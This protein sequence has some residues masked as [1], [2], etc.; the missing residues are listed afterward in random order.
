LSVSKLN[1]PVISVGNLTTGGTGKTPYVEWLCCAISEQRSPSGSGKRTRTCVLTRG[2]GRDTPKS[3]VIVSDGIKL[4]SSER[5]AGDEPFLLAKNLLGIAAVISNSDRVAAGWWAVDHLKT[6][7]FVLDDGFQHQRLSRDLDIVIVDATNPWGGGRLLPLGRL[8]EPLT[9]LSRADCIVIT[10]AEQVEDIASTE[11]TIHRLCPGVPIF[12]ARMLTSGVR[13]LDGEGLNSEAVRSE[14]LAAFCG[15]GNPGSFFK[16]LQ[17]D[18]YQILF[19]KE[20]ADHHNYKQSDVDTLVEEAKARGATSL[21]TTTKDA[22]K[23]TS[24][25]L[26]LPCFVLEIK[27]LLDD[28]EGLLQLIKDTVARTASH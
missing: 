10:R 4:L 8:R 26:Q 15:V 3:Q 16:H 22:I 27:I 20:F 12:V 17:R 13:S 19:N 5:E 18:G 24:M 11:E 28:Q 25:N 23:L 9:A 14:P 2:Y 7:V 21:I 6:E 1:A